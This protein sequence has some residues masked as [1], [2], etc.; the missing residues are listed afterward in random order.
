MPIST[1]GRSSSPDPI[2]A[3]RGFTLLEVMVVVVIIAILTALGVLSIGALG[4]DR[5]RDAEVERFE[6]VVATAMQEAQLEGRDF[7]V[8]I[9]HASYEVY[10]YSPRRQRWETVRDDRLYAVH[11]LP[12]G[13]EFGL[14]LEGRPVQLD[15]EPPA[16]SEQLDASAELATGTDR[17][18]ESPRPQL[19]FYA[20]GEVAPYRLEVRREGDTR[21]YAIEQSA[22][23]TIRT[24]SPD[25]ADAP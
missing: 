22:D 3:Q 21:A 8:R 24:T 17:R 1:R 20:G 9:Q 15:A 12:A 5:A 11:D 6:D 14:T 18:R 23:G 25:Q 7:G 10:V 13:L 2:G 16:A 4:G 19:I